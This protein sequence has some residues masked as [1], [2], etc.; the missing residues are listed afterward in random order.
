MKK[1]IIFAIVAVCLAFASCGK[2]SVTQEKSSIL[3]IVDN[4]QYGESHAFSE[5]HGQY[6][7]VYGLRGDA[8]F[9]GMTS[10]ISIASFD[11]I[12]REIE[13][14]FGPYEYSKATLPDELIEDEG[15]YWHLSKPSCE[16][17]Y[18]WSNDSLL[19]AWTLFEVQDN[20]G[21]AYLDLKWLSRE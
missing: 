20:C 12:R 13:N 10:R 5:W 3:D 6:W 16:D 19:I 1:S 8:E 21:L 14:E 17:A 7:E 15:F 9:T 4:A 18:Y 2:G 11:S